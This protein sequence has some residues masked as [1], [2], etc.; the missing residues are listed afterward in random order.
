MQTIRDD[1]GKLTP[2]IVVDVARSK[3]HPLHRRFEWNNG[4]AAEG[5]RREQARKMFRDLDVTYKK[6]GGAK[7]TVRAFHAVRYDTSTE[8][9]YEPIEEIIKDDLMTQIVRRDMV[10]DW[11]QLKTRYSY[12]EEFVAMVKADVA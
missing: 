1:H 10:R 9:V 12:F 6:S 4:I 7:R 8:Y 5:F 2:Q 11:K 3:T